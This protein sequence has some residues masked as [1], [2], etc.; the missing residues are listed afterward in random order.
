MARRLL[1]LPVMELLALRDRL[2]SALLENPA[3]VLVEHGEVVSRVLAAGEEV[4]LLAC[5]ADTLEARVT[6][7]L[8]AQKT[9]K[10]VILSVDRSAAT[11]EI[12]ARAN[13]FWQVQRQRCLY[14]ISEKDADGV[15]HVA[16]Q[17]SNVF[18]GLGR[19][20]A[21]A[22]VP[23][24]AE[25]LA[26]RLRDGQ[27]RRA[28]VDSHATALQSR[29]PAVTFA[30]G[31]VC[32]ALFLLGTVW[33]GDAYPSILGRLGAN[34]PDRVK[35]GEVWR[36][37]SAA[38]LHANFEHLLFNMLALASFGFYLERL[39]GSARF[40]VLYGLSALGG[41]L[42]SAFL[43]GHGGSVGASGA[44]WGLMAAGV[45]LSL[46]PRGLVPPLVLAG[47]KK[48]ALVPLVI[49]LL[50]S[51]TPGIDIYAHLGGG[52][53]GFLLMFS[54]VIT[55]GVEPPWGTTPA[56]QPRPNTPLV[57]AG[58][59]LVGLVLVGSVG[60]ALVAGRPWSFGDAPTYH[61][62]TVADTGISVEVP[63][64]LGDP[65]REE[66][67]PARLYTYMSPGKVPVGV[68]LVVVQ[69]DAPVG[70]DKL[71]DYLA[72]VASKNTKIEGTEQ[73]GRQEV[74]TL[75]E[76]DFVKGMFRFKAGADVHAFTT[77][78]RGD[79]LVSLRI[80]QPS[81]GLPN[82]WTGVEPRALASLRAT[83]GS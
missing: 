17:S 48:R 62:V 63:T 4:V 56:A 16:G 26:A 21:P 81:T 36:I 78:L 50:Y 64:A 11:Q 44:I 20:L 29:R 40:L 59:A 39:L 45:A 6:E 27:T 7:I 46:R 35:A 43:R 30:V 60:V 79:R 19:A 22:F 1:I 71:H 83:P 51:F 37:F 54:G 38:F 34:L 3:T 9:P 65:I 77:V 55:R 70:D 66:H 68:Q 72:E 57:A 61:T 15:S 67:G 69:L 33:A 5:A 41:G 31:A 2:L 58:A 82:N 80:F 52:L 18:V 12:L 73:V 76:H 8:R 49:N 24:D 13:T 47:M 25:A 10:I 42:A 14:M 32:V 23:L 75:A 53:V 74:V 28:E